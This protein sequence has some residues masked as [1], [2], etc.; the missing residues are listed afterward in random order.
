MDVRDLLSPAASPP[1]RQQE[2]DKKADQASAERELREVSPGFYVSPLLK[3]DTEISTLIFQVRDG[4][5]GEVERQFPSESRLEI[6]KHSALGEDAAGEREV[7][8]EPET[9]GNG[10]EQEFVE[11]PPQELGGSTETRSEPVREA[12]TTRQMT[13]GA[14]SGAAEPTDIS[15]VDLTA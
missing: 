7:P 9:D 12:E 1:S 3:F 15:R 2:P 6:L 8:V 10:A 14:A 13:H 4:E 5:S 11:R